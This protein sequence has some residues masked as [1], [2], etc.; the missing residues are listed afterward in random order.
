MSTCRRPRWWTA[1]SCGG[2]PLGRLDFAALQRRNTA[3]RRAADLARAEPCHYIVFDLLEAGGQDLRPEPLTRRRQMLEQVFADVPPA[4]TLA[5]SMATDQVEQARTWLAT[6]P[7][8][9]VEGVMIK[10]AGQPYL[11]G[12]RGWAKLKHHST[13]G[14]IVGGVTGTFARPG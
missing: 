14:A 1:R 5:L 11:P 12:R 4:A 9:G 10:P 7:A 6:L 8:A 2:Q 13:T 3:G